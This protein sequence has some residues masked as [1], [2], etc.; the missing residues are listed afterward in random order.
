MEGQ[1]VMNNVTATKN[2][3]FK[4]VSDQ[5]R[6][7]EVVIP[8]PAKKDVSFRQAGDQSWV[9]S[10]RKEPQSIVST[11]RVEKA[12]PELAV[13]VFEYGRSAFLMRV[14]LAYTDLKRR[15]MTG[16]EEIP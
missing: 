2:S 12:G 13:E 16:K 9:L 15:G 1:K 6:R 7:Q 8:T 3:L 14:P 11:L 10:W 5:L 4:L